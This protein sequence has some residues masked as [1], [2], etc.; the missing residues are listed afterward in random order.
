MSRAASGL[1]GAGDLDEVA[2][3]KRTLGPTTIA[4]HYNAIVPTGG[5]EGGEEGGAAAKKKKGAAKKKPAAAAAK[6][7]R[8]TPNRSS[9]PPPCSTTGGWARRAGR[10]SPTARAP[11]RRRRRVGRPSA[12][13][14]AS[15]ATPTRPCASTASTT[16]PAPLNLSGKSAIT[17]EFW[18]KWNSYAN[19]DRLAMEFTNNFNE[20]AGGFL[21]DPN[22]PQ[23]GGSF[24]VGIGKGASRNNVFFARPTA[25]QWH[26]YAFV[27]D[28]SAP[29]A[30][31]ITPT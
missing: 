2:I 3:Y 26:H 10:R 27:L 21:V 18:L 1:F 15:K 14:A 22:A 7:R 13:R 28:T 20:T 16:P 31:Q 6:G 23:L 24:G 8:R 5:G 11:A 25:G 4:D 19:D 30:Q 9:A 12:T 17:V 29:A